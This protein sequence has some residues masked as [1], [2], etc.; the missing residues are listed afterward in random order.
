M[1]R[2]RHHWIV[3]LR[4]PHWVLVVV[5]LVLLLAAAVWP[6]ADGWVFAL[7]VGSWA[8]VRWQTW[9]AESVI[10]TSKRVMRV[11]GVPETTSTE[12]SLRLD[13]ISG[14]VL[15]ETVPG[16]LLD[17]G[18]IELEAPGRPPRRPQLV[19]IERPNAVLPAAAT[20]GVRR[21]AR[22]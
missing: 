6:R 8:F 7:A 18:T 19:K 21:T 15:G 10:L 3:L 13:R 12:A 20:G 22:P 14:I 16:K 5:L 2:T 4:P 1:A 9:Q 11:H 17:Y